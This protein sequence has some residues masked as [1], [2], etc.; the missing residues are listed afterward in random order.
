MH[1]SHNDNLRNDNFN[2]KD[3]IKIDCFYYHFYI[4]KDELKNYNLDENYVI[5]ITETVKKENSISPVKKMKDKISNIFDN[6]SIKTDNQF[7]CFSRILAIYN[8]KNVKI[9][10][11]PIYNLFNN[12]ITFD[13]KKR[14]II[15]Y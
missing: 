10:D 2:N 6:F 8:T 9:S 14:D 7:D 13:F 3:R 1:N 5:N 11:K 15:L 4:R 12:L